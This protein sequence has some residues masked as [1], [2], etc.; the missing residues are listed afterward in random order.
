M[1]S[2]CLSSVALFEW[3]ALEDSAAALGGAGVASEEAAASRR[4]DMIMGAR[5]ASVLPEPGPGQTDQTQT[6]RALP[7]MPLLV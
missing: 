1:L 5:N 2:I 6:R 3:N 7:V 4:S